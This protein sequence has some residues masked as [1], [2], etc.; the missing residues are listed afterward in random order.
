MGTYDEKSGNWMN[1]K[2]KPRSPMD[3]GNNR[4]DKS[5]CFAAAAVKSA[6]ARKWRLARRYSRLM[7]VTLARRAVA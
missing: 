7:A 5:C 3:S 2:K 6:K 4:S 1:P